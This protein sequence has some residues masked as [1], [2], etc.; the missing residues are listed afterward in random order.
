MSPT[1]G[2]RLRDGKRAA[3]QVQPEDTRLLRDVLLAQTLGQRDV[4]GFEASCTGER[5]S[6][7]HGHSSRQACAKM[8]PRRGACAQPEPAGT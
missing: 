8:G 1:E 5:G 6:R 2:A 7:P 3:F 4:L